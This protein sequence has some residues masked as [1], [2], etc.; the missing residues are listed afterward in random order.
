MEI[1]ETTPAIIQRQADPSEGVDTTPPPEVK[2]A[3]PGAAGP[4]APA[5]KIDT[6]ELARRVYSTIKRR[7]SVEW[8]RIRS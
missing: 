5:Q 8:E 2:A 4:E 3:E 7:L 1:Y 6:D